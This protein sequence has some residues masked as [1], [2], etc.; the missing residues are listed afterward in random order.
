[1]MEFREAVQGLRAGDFSRLE[2]LFTGG[3]P[4]DDHLCRI[5]EWYDEGLF[6]GE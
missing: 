1:M 4:P 3:V 5:A 6:A 2:P